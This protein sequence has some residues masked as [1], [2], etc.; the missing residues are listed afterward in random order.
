MWWPTYNGAPQGDSVIHVVSSSAAHG[1]LKKYPWAASHRC[2][3]SNFTTF[4]FSTPS[5]TTSDRGCARGRSTTGRSRR[6]LRPS[7]PDRDRVS[8]VE[9]STNNDGRLVRRPGP[10]IGEERVPRPVRADTR[11]TDSTQL[12]T[13]VAAALLRSFQSGGEDHGHQTPLHP[14]AKEKW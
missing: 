12:L 7:A 8:I 4:S 2:S 14:G 13:L 5:A 1:R 3:L 11:F 6:P 9:R 10:E